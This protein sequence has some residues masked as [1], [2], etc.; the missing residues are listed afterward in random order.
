M[1]CDAIIEGGVLGRQQNNWIR[2]HY[3]G[4]KVNQNKV[5]KWM[6]RFKE[7]PSYADHGV[8]GPHLSQL[9]EL[10]SRSITVSVTT[11]ETRIVKIVKISSE[12]NIT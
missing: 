8:L 6:Q 4:N 1:I 9:L 10:R 3:C 5:H 2:V 11:E 7:G 12:V